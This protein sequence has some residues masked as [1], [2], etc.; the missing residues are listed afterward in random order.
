ML[1]K[2][3]HFGEIDIED[4]KIIDFPNGIMG[5]ENCKKYTLLYDVSDDKDKFSISWLQSLEEPGFALPVVNPYHVKPDYNPIV[6]DEILKTLG[7][8][9]EE[10]LVIL[11]SLTVPTDI[12]KM[13]ANLKAPFI[14]NSDTRK[15]TQLIVENQDYEIK[16]NIYD[17]IQMLKNVKGDTSC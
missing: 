10:N 15:G 17:N 3:K 13:S 8:I 7:A 2:T 11:L 14:I 9:N 16:Y 6:E 12:T 4:D 5:F 1:V